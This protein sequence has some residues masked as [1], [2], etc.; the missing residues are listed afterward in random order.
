M[1]GGNVTTP[2]V[3]PIKWGYRFRQNQEC[4]LWTRQFYFSQFSAAAGSKVLD[5]TNFAGGLLIE[6]AFCYVHTAF[7]GGAV[8]ATAFSAGTTGSAALYINAQDVFTNADAV[9]PGVAIVPG[10]TLS[11][12]T[13]PRA[14]ATVRLTIATT[15]A[16]TNA[17]TAGSLTLFL[18]LRAVRLQ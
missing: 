18:Y 17:L 16:N 4:R 11:T 15:T 6:G 14:T 7:T 3:E 12:S 1:A 5:I 8:S 10:T 2:G 9:L 13:T